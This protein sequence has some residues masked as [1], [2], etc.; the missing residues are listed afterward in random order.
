MNLASLICREHKVSP[1]EIMLLRHANVSVA[2]L[3]RFGASMEEYTAIQPI[4]SRYD[5]W[6]ASQPQVTVVVV[7][8]EDH[9][10]G[11]YRVVGV[12]GEG[13]NYSLG[14]DAYK[15]FESDRA[16]PAPVLL[17]RK[18]QLQR[19][20]S[21]STGL[22][23][24]GWEGRTRTPVQRSADT[25]FAEIEV[26]PTDDADMGME[27]EAAFQRQVAAALLDSPSAREARLAIADRLPR[28]VTVSASIFVRNADVVAEV[29][30]RAGGVCESCD[31]PAPFVRRVDATPYLEVHHKK[32]LADGGEDTVENA[33]AVCPNCHRGAHYG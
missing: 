19:L 11:V 33:I 7:I 18:F 8:V 23:V 13:T 5:Y 2:L 4:D 21:V 32:R 12:E 25:F 6:R 30:A 1:E 10:Q 26:G 24:R 22:R 9:V 27:V 28:R 29:L 14:S 15:R 16:N 31:K 17:C 20:A 3:R